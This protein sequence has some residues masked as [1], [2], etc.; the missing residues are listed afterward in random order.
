MVSPGVRRYYDIQLRILSASTSAWVGK[1]GA[2]MTFEILLLVFALWGTGFIVGMVFGF[3]KGHGFLQVVRVDT[4][5][6]VEDLY[7]KKG[8]INGSDAN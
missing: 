8:D 4:S 6:K 2:R 1:V 3:I 7:P 5:V